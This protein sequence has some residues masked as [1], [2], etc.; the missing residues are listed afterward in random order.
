MISRKEAQAK[1]NEYCG[2][3]GP[4]DE[5]Y[6]DGSKIDKRVGAA[7]VINRHF[8]NGEITRRCLSKRLPHNS[9]SFVAEAT[10]L[11]MALD[12][13]QHMEPVRR[14]VV[15]YSDAMSC[16]KA[17]E[18]EDTEN[19]LICYIMNPL[20]LLSDKGTHVCF[21]LIP[22]HCGIE[23]NEKVDQ[24]A[25]ESL[26]HD[27]DPLARGHYADLKPLINSY[28]QQLVQIKWDVFVHGRDLY[29]LKSILGPPK[30]FQHLTR[31]EEIVITRLRIGHTKATKS[32]IL[33]RD[34]PATCHH[35]GQTLTIDHLL[36]ECAALQEGRDE[37]Y[38]ADSLKTLFEKIS[39]TCI[40]EFVRQA[41]V[42]YLI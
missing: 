11:T 25:K 6:T 17:I 41:G 28:I 38:T 33:S 3:L 39:E 12:Y 23:G 5:V 31:A 21:C 18:G 1:F 40:V 4:H 16:L 13:Y 7:A 15:V 36:L 32:H 24:S 10:A 35:C 34:P 20:W 22:S 29:L 26:D 27:I 2:T 37:Y 8:Q 30:K 14:D 19:P 42:L 9:T